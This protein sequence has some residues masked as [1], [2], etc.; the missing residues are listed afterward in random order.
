VLL[1]PIFERTT[2]AKPALIAVTSLF[3]R[4]NGALIRI[5]MAARMLYRMRGI[6]LSNRGTP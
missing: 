1:G 5:V 6:T 4:V 2:G 3:A